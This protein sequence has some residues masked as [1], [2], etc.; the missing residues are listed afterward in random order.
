[1]RKL[2]KPK[3]ISPDLVA[4]IQK[5]RQ[6]CSLNELVFKYSIAYPTIAAICKGI[7]RE[8]K[9]DKDTIFEKRM[10]GSFAF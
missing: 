5:D 1:M 10:M 7:E 9:A 3:D 2:I 8:V 6:S 4:A